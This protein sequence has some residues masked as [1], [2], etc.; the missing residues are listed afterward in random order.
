MFSEEFDGLFVT[1]FPSADIGSRFPVSMLLAG[2]ADLR[3]LGSDGELSAHGHDK[4]ASPSP[5]PQGD[6]H[7]RHPARLEDTREHMIVRPAI[8][9]RFTC[10][11]LLHHI[12][13]QG[14]HAFVPGD[15]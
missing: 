3:D 11:R 1:A 4:R 7:G 5:V 14:Q 2:D 12:G 15:E 8:D 10:R 9:T 13:R 6:H